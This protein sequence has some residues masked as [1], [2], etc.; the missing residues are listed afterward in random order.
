MVVGMP[1][2]YN[3]QKVQPEMQTSLRNIPVAKD[4]SKFSKTLYALN[5]TI[6]NGGGADFHAQLHIHLLKPLMMSIMLPV[7]STH[8]WI[9]RIRSSIVYISDEPTSMFTIY[10]MIF[11]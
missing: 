8:I 2:E 10:Q 1:E 7:T 4:D 6:K 11:V 5:I 3:S 9:A